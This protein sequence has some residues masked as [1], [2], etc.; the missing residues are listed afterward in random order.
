MFVW[1]E[2]LGLFLHQGFVTFYA[3]NYDQHVI[4]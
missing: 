3:N 2:E 1:I 4:L